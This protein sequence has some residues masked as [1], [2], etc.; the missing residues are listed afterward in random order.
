MSAIDWSMKPEPWRTI[1]QSFADNL[2]AG[3][4]GYAGAK[5]IW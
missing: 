4:S 1:G 2:A 3:G 5:I